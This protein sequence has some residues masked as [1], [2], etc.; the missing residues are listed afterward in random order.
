MSAQLMRDLFAI[1]EFLYTYLVT[2][3]TGLQAGSRQVAIL[4]V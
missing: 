1:A 4:A 3:Y 2:Y